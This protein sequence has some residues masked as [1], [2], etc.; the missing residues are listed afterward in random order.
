[1]KTEGFNRFL[2]QVYLRLVGGM[3]LAACTAWL[4]AD[5]PGLRHVFR[6]DGA[7]VVAGYTG[8]GLMVL[9]APLV[10]TAVAGWSLRNG[11]DRGVKTT[12]W[13]LA[14]Q[15]G[16]AISLLAL[17][18]HGAGLAS[19]FAAAAGSFVIVSLVGARRGRGLGPMDGF[20]IAALSGALLA[21]GLDLAL[22]RPAFVLVVDMVGAAVLAALAAWN[23]RRLRTIYARLEDEDLSSGADLGALGLFLDFN[24]VQLFCNFNDRRRRSP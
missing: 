15:S 12:F 18:L 13:M 6:D 10:V 22:G 1:M 19:A 2:A 11:R 23:I 5:V 8:L 3:L 14:A 17:P 21:A 4:V 20:L 24:P 9:A 16:A 7:G